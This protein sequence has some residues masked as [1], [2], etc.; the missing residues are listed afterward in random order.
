MAFDVSTY[1]LL[2]PFLDAIDAM[3]LDRLIACFSPEVEFQLAETTPVLVGKAALRMFYEEHWHSFS[4]QKAISRTFLTNGLEVI[5]ISEL[6]V[7][8]PEMGEGL[9]ILPIVQRFVFE[10][11]G[12]IVKLTDFLD[13]KRA[14]HTS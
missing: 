5:S 7:P 2:K 6:K 14:I 9:F 13:F 8:I 3:D 11:S 4:G 10:P 12:L 1:G